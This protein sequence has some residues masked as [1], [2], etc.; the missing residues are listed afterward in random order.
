[1]RE[2]LLRSDFMFKNLKLC[3]SFHPSSFQVASFVYL[4]TPFTGTEAVSMGLVHETLWPARYNE[5]LYSRVHMISSQSALIRATKRTVRSY[6]LARNLE[7]LWAEWDGIEK[8]W[9]TR[10]FQDRARAFL[11]RTFVNGVSNRGVS[12]KIP[13]SS[14]CPTNQP[15]ASASATTSAQTHPGSSSTVLLNGQ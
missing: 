13:S 15:N 1:M 4:N 5:E 8:E 7:L 10:G 3:V 2:R 9:G 11:N 6:T 14:G 12:T